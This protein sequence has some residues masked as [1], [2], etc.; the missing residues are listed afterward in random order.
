[1]HTE[2]MAEILCLPRVTQTI[3]KKQVIN[4][5]THLNK[6]LKACVIDST[7]AFSV[8]LFEFG[9]TFLINKH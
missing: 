8:M 1:M 4:D 7:N 9:Y 2:V 3:T 5:F 6:A